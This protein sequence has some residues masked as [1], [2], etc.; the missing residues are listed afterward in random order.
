MVGDAAA[1]DLVQDTFLAAWRGLPRLRDTD[2]FGP[3]LHRIA[4]N[5]ARSDLRARRH[6]SEIALSLSPDAHPATV[7]L[8]GGVEIRAD[9]MP[10]LRALT[11]DQQTVVALHY[12]AGLTIAQTAEALGIPPGTVKSRLNAA[13]EALRWRL[14]PEADA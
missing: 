2:R 3:W 4:V 14:S 1:D 5:R 6:I 7:D 12:A 13:L 9:L 8:R 11:E 10:A